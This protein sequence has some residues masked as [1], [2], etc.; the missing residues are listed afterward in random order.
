VFEIQML[1]PVA[2]NGGVTFTAEH[3]RAFEVA[4][5]NRFGGFSIYPT[6]TVGSWR[7]D[8]GRVYVDRTR[9]YSIAIGSIAAGAKIASLA[10]FAKRHYRQEAIFIRYLGQAEVL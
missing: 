5:L 4:I 1:I 7:D 8:D 3:H 9:V 10:R 2:D 6:E